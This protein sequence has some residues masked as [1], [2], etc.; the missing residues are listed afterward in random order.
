LHTPHYIA[1]YAADDTLAAA[2]VH[3]NSQV[4]ITMLTHSS[5]LLQLR[6]GPS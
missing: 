4:H 2:D 5:D 3:D 6:M 1:L